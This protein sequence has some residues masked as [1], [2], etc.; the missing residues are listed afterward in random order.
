M[1]TKAPWSD[2][3]V[4]KLNEWQTCGWVHPFTCVYRGDEY[5]VHNGD[6]ALVAERDGWRCPVCEYHQDWAH[7]FMLQ[8]A[9]P[10]PFSESPPP[11]E[12]PPPPPEGL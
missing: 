10:K 5:H 6:C 2:E 12:V 4:A 7:D 8:G 3:Q 11:A 9:P 1:L